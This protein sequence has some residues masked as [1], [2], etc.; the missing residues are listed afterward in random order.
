MLDAAA[1]SISFDVASNLKAANNPFTPMP[2]HTELELCDLAL[3]ACDNISTRSALCLR[4]QSCEGQRALCCCSGK[5]TVGRVPSPEAAAVCKEL[6]L[7][8]DFEGVA[9]AS[10]RVRSVHRDKETRRTISLKVRTCSQVDWSACCDAT[11]HKRAV[12]VV[13]ISQSRWLRLR[14]GGLCLFGRCQ[15]LS[16]QRV[17]HTL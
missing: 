15:A 3:E 14:G 11:C 16:V 13:D 10:V 1:V 2:R 17:R 9:H 6:G 7:A 8:D 12:V 5:D 4:V